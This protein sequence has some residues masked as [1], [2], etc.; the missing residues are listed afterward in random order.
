MPVTQSELDS[1][2]FGYRIGRGRLDGAADLGALRAELAGYDIAIVRAPLED[3]LLP[4]ALAGL[5][6]YRAFTADHLLYWEW[7]GGAVA[8]VP[9][10]PGYRV[11]TCDDPG[12]VV[13]VLRSSFAGYRNHYAA[14][15]LLDPAGALEGYVE[16]TGQLMGSGH[17]TTVVVEDD[18]AAVVAFG[19][20]D[21]SP[22]APDIRLAG[23]GAGAQGGGVY[24][25]LIRDLMAAA[26]DRERLPLQ[27]STQSSNTN[28]MRAWARLGFVPVETLATYHLVAERLLSDGPP[29]R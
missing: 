2:R 9:L 25:H 29:D 26:E 8:P 19:I 16:W 15:P 3:P 18:R 20:V 27:I 5:A 21:W 12:R 24:G 10:P 4:A 28:V 7:R 23:V 13:P 22:P 1:R 17:A 14:N 11:L 6:G